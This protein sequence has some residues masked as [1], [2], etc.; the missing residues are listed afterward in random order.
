MKKKTLVVALALVA[1]A[2]MTACGKTETKDATDSKE[3]VEDA[4]SEDAMRDMEDDEDY[5][6]NA[7][8]ERVGKTS[9]ESFDEIIG[10]LEGEEGYAYVDVRGNGEKVLFVA[11]YT[12]D[13]QLGH[14]ATNECTAYSVHSDGVCRADSAFTSDGTSS[15]IKIDNQGMVFSVTHESVDKFCYGNNGSDTPAIMELECIYANEF[16]D[17]GNV[18]KVGGFLRTKNDLTDD[19]MV[20]VSEYD[21]ETYNRLFEEYAN[22]EVI[23]FTRANGDEVSKQD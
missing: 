14:F 22:A 17:N 20:E 9:F 21:I 18:I 7:F 8:E 15:P 13:D 1:V 10:L 3:V 5:P 19:D 12:F 16:D 6:N 23:N 2:A 4:S 11:T